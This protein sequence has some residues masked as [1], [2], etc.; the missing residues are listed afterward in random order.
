ML[1]QEAARA[2]KFRPW[3]PDWQTEARYTAAQVDKAGENDII[4]LQAELKNAEAST[5]R[6]QQK[7]TEKQLLYMALARRNF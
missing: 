4:R 6:A 2:E 3:S 7:R 5:T 1:V